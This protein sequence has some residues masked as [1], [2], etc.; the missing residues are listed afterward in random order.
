MLCEGPDESKVNMGPGSASAVAVAVAVVA[1]PHRLGKLQ[2]SSHK[3]RE[4]LSANGQP[5]L[6]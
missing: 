3:C 2:S 6:G 1:P 5:H 4:A